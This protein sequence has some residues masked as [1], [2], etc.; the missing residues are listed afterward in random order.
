MSV[1]PSRVA[2]SVDVW[3]VAAVAASA[4]VALV[5]EASRVAVVW[6]PQPANSPNSAKDGRHDVIA[7]A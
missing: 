4:S 7:A 6:S 1:D 3:S 5:A 2:V